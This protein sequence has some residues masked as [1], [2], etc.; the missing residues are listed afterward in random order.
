M[1]FGCTLSLTCDI[2]IASET[3][4]FGAVWVRV[5]LIGDL[6]ATYLLPR[7]VGPDKALEM[8]TTGDMI[9]AQE[10]ERIGLVTRVVPPD[11]LM[12]TVKELATKMAKGA[13]LSIKFTK[14]A[15]YKGLQHNDL[16][17]QLDYESFA[18]G[19]CRQSEDH[20]EGV[21]AFMEKRKPQFKGT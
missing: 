12:P 5:G 1:G 15:V 8:L 2:R 21:K 16:L 19:V 20:R 6:G 14:K 4:R 18:Q 7:I 3:A 10:A 11:E 17:T 9:S 13:G